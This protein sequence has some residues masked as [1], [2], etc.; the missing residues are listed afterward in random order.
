SLNLAMLRRR[1]LRPCLTF[2]FVR[3]VLP[4]IPPRAGRQS[5]GDPSASASD[6]RAATSESQAQTEAARSTILGWSVSI[7]VPMAI[8][9]LDRQPGHRDRL[10]P[11][12]LPLVLDLEDSIW[13][14]RTAMRSERN[15]RT[16][17]DT[18]PRQ[19][20]LGNAQNS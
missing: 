12:Q 19:C 16:D 8:R 2:D 7:V 5:T 14:P 3:F 6:R 9:A 13:T 1:L 20:G 11:S 15:K 17:S 18:K 4:R 10:A